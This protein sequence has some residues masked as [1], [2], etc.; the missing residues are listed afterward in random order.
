V[1]RRRCSSFIGRR[2]KGRRRGEAVA[3]A[4]RWRPSMAAAAALDRATPV[5]RV[6]EAR[7]SERAA[8]ELSGVLY[9]VRR[10]EGRW[11]RATAINGYGGGRSSMHS[12]GGGA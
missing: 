8:Q 1:E 7:G 11:P 12:R 4:R 3:V 9:R 2:G 6:R 5:G 10:G